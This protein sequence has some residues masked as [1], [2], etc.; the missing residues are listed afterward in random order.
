MFSALWAGDVSNFVIIVYVSICRSARTCLAALDDH[1]SDWSRYSISDSAIGVT[2]SSGTE[3]KGKLSILGPSRL[4]MIL[5]IRLYLAVRGQNR[6]ASYFSTS[7]ATRYPLATR[8]AGLIKRR[9]QSLIWWLMILEASN[10]MKSSHPTPFSGSAMPVQ[11]VERPSVVSINLA[12][13]L[14]LKTRRCGP[15]VSSGCVRLRHFLE[16]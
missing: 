6:I 4:R 11:G 7:A 13:L 5:V 14:I 1:S 8:S 10:S 9:V 3:P 2:R 12:L 16:P 15:T